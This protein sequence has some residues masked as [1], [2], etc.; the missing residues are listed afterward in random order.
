MN[1]ML[2]RLMEKKKYVYTC[3]NKICAFSCM[4][5]YRA[6]CPCIKYLNHRLIYWIIKHAELF[7]QI[8]TIKLCINDDFKYTEKDKYI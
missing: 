5:K 2:M 8:C 6:D 3:I 1:N 7:L 4:Y